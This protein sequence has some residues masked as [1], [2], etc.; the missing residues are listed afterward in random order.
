MD[1]FERLSRWVHWGGECAPID[2]LSIF[3]VEFTDEGEEIP[4]HHCNGKK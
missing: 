3:L 2:V 1:E 4:F